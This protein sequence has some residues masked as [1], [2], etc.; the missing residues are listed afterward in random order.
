MASS[1]PSGDP[2]AQ[3]QQLEQA[4]GRWVEHC[5][6]PIEALQQLRQGL[7]PAFQPLLLSSQ[8]TLAKLPSP[9]AS[10]LLLAGFAASFPAY[11]YVLDPT[12]L[13]A[14]AHAVERHF[15]LHNSLPE[16][17]TLDELR[18]MFYV[19]WKHRQHQHAGEVREA[20][21]DY[22]AFLLAQM[23]RQLSTA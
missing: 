12:L 4:L 2:L 19:G 7:N 14:T 13:I 8:L 3:Y 6:R 11:E 20:G 16:P 15:F 21:A 9:Q 18:A 5:K 10:A 17:L 22:L 1:H 23:Q